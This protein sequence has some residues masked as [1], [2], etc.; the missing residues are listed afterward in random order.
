MK[1]L[2]ILLSALMPL[3]SASA[4]ESKPLV[5]PGKTWWYL[6]ETYDQKS[7]GHIEKTFGLRIAE[8]V[9]IDGREWFACRQ[10]DASDRTSVTGDAVVYLRQDGQYAYC[11]PASARPD[12]GSGIPAVGFVLYDP[13]AVKGGTFPVADLDGGFQRYVFSVGEVGC[14]TSC[15]IERKVL[16]GSI[17]DGG[18]VPEVTDVLLIDGIGFDN[19]RYGGLFYR[20]S[21]QIPSG[22]S[23]WS[24]WLQGVVDS[25][26]NLLWVADESITEPWKPAGISDATADTSEWS[27]A[28]G[29]VSIFADATVR[30]FDMSGRIVVAPVALPAGGT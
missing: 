6:A 3:L 7:G 4:Y 2:I 16:T 12:A 5:E 13:D 25:E 11:L 18:D 19:T 15:G 9:Q 28:C 26:E 21:I 30:V 23:Y 20:P 24:Y 22:F 8:S 17:S 10:V 1:K 29:T 27:Y 14:E